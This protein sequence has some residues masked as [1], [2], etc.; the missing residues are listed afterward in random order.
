MNQGRQDEVVGR[1]NDALDVPGIDDTTREGVLAELMT[2]Q[3]PAVEAQP[4]PAPV[5][6]PQQD[7][8]LHESMPHM[9]ALTSLRF[10]AAMGVMVGH[11]AGLFGLPRYTWQLAQAVSLFFVLSGFLLVYQYPSLPLRNVGRF[12]LARAA[13]IW[14]VYLVALAF[15]LVC[16]SHFMSNTGQWFQTNGVRLFLNLFLVQNWIILP[17]VDARFNTSLN[18]PAWTLSALIAMYLLYPVLI[19]KWK[20]TWHI[21]LAASATVLVLVFVLCHTSEFFESAVFTIGPYRVSRWVYGHFFSRIFEFIV[22]MCAAL[23]WQKLAHRYTSRVGTATALEAGSILVG[24][25]AVVLSIIPLYWAVETPWA[26]SPVGTWIGMGGMTSFFWAA[27]V[28]V[29]AFGRGR[30]S[31]L[32]SH[33]LPVLLGTISYSLYLTHFQIVSFYRLRLKGF[34][35]MPGVILFAIFVL[36]SLVVAYFVWSWVEEPVRRFF[37]G[38]NKQEQTPKLLTPP[39][40][41]RKRWWAL[42]AQAASVVLVA[43]VWISMGHYRPNVEMSDKE[44]LNEWLEGARLETRNVAFGKQITLLGASTTTLESGGM[45]IRLVWK[46]ETEVALKYKIGVHMIDRPGGKPLAFNDAH[47]DAAHSTVPTGSIWE[48]TITIPPGKL[49]D[50]NRI[51]L[52]LYEGKTLL[53]IASG[54]RDWE[55]KRLLLPIR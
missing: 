26:G 15:V 12:Y 50:A 25:G 30:V 54:P 10:F 36:V 53:P 27:M 33:P 35:P 42:G 14:P 37:A 11:S 43:I 16:D 41:W 3:K 34:P 49:K 51:G 29:F 18:P 45:E 20:S 17:G 8:V 7:I 32:L 39:Y 23:L 21:K 24:L 2:I 1:S 13:R 38:Q 22:G 31:K 9:P 47:L 46:A 4:E 52:A 48:N 44:S 6:P 5:L 28:I 40:Q 55:G 19:H